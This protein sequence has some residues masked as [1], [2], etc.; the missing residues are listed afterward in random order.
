MACSKKG[1]AVFLAERVAIIKELSIVD[2]VIAFDDSD[3]TAQPKQ[4]SNNEYKPSGKVIFANGGDR[5]Q[6][7]SEYKMYGDHHCR[8]CVWSRWGF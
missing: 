3:D 2:K 7:Y 1:R 5:T 8:I 6:Y 4:Y